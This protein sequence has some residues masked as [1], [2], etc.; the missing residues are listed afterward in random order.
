MSFTISTPTRTKE[1]RRHAAHV[2]SFLHAGPLP[3]ERGWAWQHVLLNRR[4]NYMRRM[5][6][7]EQNQITISEQQQLH[8]NDNNDWVL[9]FEHEPVYT[10]GRGASEEHLTFLNSE[11]D[12]GVE[13]RRRVSRKYRGEMRVHLG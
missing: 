12:G 4:L 7:Q 2:K 9:L 5:Q 13:K 1:N 8:N 10:L 11:S 6:Q 3:Y